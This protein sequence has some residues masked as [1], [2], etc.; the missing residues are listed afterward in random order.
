MEQ[1]VS[2]VRELSIGMLCDADTNTG[3]DF[4]SRMLSY[5]HD[6]VLKN[7]L[8]ITHLQYHQHE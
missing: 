3:Q 7:I 8:T 5:L 4:V 1:G 6:T 2:V